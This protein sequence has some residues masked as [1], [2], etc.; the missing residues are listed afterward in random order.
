LATTDY[1]SLKFGPTNP[2]K[3]L[4]HHYIPTF[5]RQA[6]KAHGDESSDEE[7]P[8]SKKNRSSRCVLCCPH[9]FVHTSTLVIVQTREVRERFEKGGDQ[10]ADTSQ[11]A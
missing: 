3:K 11:E 9:P 7:L 6:L 8:P 1:T 10:E 5:G 2:A 4:P